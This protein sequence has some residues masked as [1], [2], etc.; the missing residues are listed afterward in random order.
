MA[1]DGQDATPGRSGSS[2]VLSL[3]RDA[4]ATSANAVPTPAFMIP[5]QGPVVDV[6]TAPTMP[7]T[8]SFGEGPLSAAEQ[9]H[10][11]AAFPMG[12][13]DLHL[14]VQSRVS[15]LSR[16]CLVTFCCS[17]N[18]YICVI[19]V[20]YSSADL[21]LFTPFTGGGCRHVQR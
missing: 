15:V 6:S 4:E 10:N 12:M 13:T 3:L 20:I 7:K 16:S 8:P 5:G 9:V 19:V 14:A 18:K 17:Y 1:L 21:N 11:H 2:A